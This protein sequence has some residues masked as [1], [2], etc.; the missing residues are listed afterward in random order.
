M[1]GDEV[2][3]TEE[4]Q[5]VRSVM[6]D[7][8]RGLPQS[9]TIGIGDWTD[10]SDGDFVLFVA[11]WLVAYGNRVAVIQ[12][13][14]ASMARELTELREQRAAVRSFLGTTPPAGEQ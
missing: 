9:D 4:R 11:E 12:T 2:L 14:A 6:L 7:A 3:R 13:T 1:S 8:I 10:Q 5:L